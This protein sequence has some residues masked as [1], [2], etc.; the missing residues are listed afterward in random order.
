M[1]V[2]LGIG[3]ELVLLPSCPSGLPSTIITPAD[4]SSLR[5]SFL[6]QG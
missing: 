6:I 2:F 3:Q 4:S 5:E 1:S